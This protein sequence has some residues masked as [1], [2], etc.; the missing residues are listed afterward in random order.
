MLRLKLHL[1]KLMDPEN[2]TFDLHHPTNTDKPR[3][4]VSIPHAGEMIP[5]I[6]KLFLTPNE[7]YLREDVDYKVD[8]LIDISKLNENGI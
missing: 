7:A 4:I 3:G 6:F 5:E 1:N 2:P 8:E